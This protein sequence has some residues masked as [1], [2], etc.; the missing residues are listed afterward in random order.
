MAADLNREGPGMAG[1]PDLFQRFVET[2]A[3][4]RSLTEAIVFQSDGTVVARTGLSFVLDFEGLPIRHLEE[5]SR[6][7]VTLTSDADD[8]V[9]ALIRLDSFADAYLYVGRFVEPT[10]LG[11]MESTEQLV[12]EYELLALERSGIQI[13]FALVF[14]LVALLLLLAAVW[15]GLTFANRLVTPLSQL[16]VAAERV[17]R[18]DLSARVP[19]GA[20]GDEI[21][22]LSLAFNRMTGELAGQRQALVEAN[23]QIDERRRFTEAVLSDVSSGVLGLDPH[24]R[25]TFANRAAAAFLGRLPAE[26]TGQALIGVVP[27][28]AGLLTRVATT[29]TGSAAEQIDVVRA[30]HPRTLLVHASAQQDDDGLTGFVVAFDDLSELLAA[31]RKAAWS[32]IARRIAH[33]I[34]NPLTPIQLS[35]ERLK[36]RYLRQI[37]EDPETFTGCTDTI[38]R[39]VDSIRRLIDE[40]SAFA[41]MPAPVFSEQSAVELVRQAVTMQQV[42][43]PEIAF[44]TELPGYDLRLYCDPHQVAQALTNLL[45]NAVDSVRARH[46]GRGD[47]HITVRVAERGDTCIV[48]VLDDGLGLPAALRDRLTQPYVTGRPDG[49]GLGLAIVDKIMEQHGGSIALED[50]PEG[51]ACARLVFPAAARRRAAAS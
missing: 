32:E 46:G 1:Q 41:R 31:Q 35:A 3:L 40:F 45:Q 29:R 4:V 51:G 47:G 39:Q 38:V 13:T 6:D 17:S 50:R 21:S 37:K 33:E 28:L 34:K 12:S 2:Q 44:S 19:V 25:I 22:S 16:I 49:T 15:V 36:R 26:L 48:E 18:G 14:G 20:K 27:E 8:R 11:H 24:G 30:G 7:V 10:V 42:A 43:R 23:E 9:R 5:A